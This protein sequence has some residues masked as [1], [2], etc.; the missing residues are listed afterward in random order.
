MKLIEKK[1]YDLALSSQEK[2]F[3]P[4]IIDFFNNLGKDVCN[5]Y[6]NCADCP[7]FKDCDAIFGED[8]PDAAIRVFFR[9]ILDDCN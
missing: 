7:L 5:N 2:E 8:R 1:K 6:E 3:I 4:Q 9:N